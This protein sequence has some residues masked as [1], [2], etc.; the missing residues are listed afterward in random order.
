MYY[1]LI[2]YQT[3][4]LPYIDK[5]PNLSQYS[6]FYSNTKKNSIIQGVIFITENDIIKEL[7]EIP[8][9]INRLIHLN[10]SYNK[11]KSVCYLNYEKNKVCE[12]YPHNSEYIKVILQCCKNELDS[13]CILWVCLDNINNID[14]YL[15]EGFRNPSIVNVTPLN[16]NIQTECLN[17]TRENKDLIFDPQNIFNPH[18]KIGVSHEFAVRYMKQ[19]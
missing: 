7:D 6:D 3:Q 17:L 16:N 11:I 18:K 19:S 13:K 8:R 15:I 10:N 12:L 2:N 5:M 4:F 1:I 9:G 14:N